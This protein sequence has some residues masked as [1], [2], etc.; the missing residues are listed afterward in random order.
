M[1]KCVKVSLFDLPSL[2]PEFSLNI[3]TW[4]TSVWRWV[5]STCPLYSL[6]SHWTSKLDEQV[7]EDESPQPALFIPWIF[8]EHPNLMNKCVKMSLLNLPSLFPEFSLNIQT[9]WTSVWRWVSST[10]P[11][12]SLNFHWTSKLDEQVCDGESPQPALYLPWILIE[13]PNLMNKCVKVSLLNLPSLFPEFS[14][15]ILTWWTSVWRWVSSTCPLYSLNSH[16]T[17]KLDEQVCE[18]ESPQPALYLPWILIEHPNL[19][20]KCVK[21]SLLNLPSLFPEFSL[22]IRTWWTSV[23]RWVSSTCP[24][25][26]LNSHWTFKLD[27]K[28]VKV[29]L[30]LPSFFPEFSLN[31]QTWWTSV[32]RW[33]SSTCP[34]YSLNSHWIS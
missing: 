27:N 33:V 6:N 11:L 25:Y 5:S 29:S 12:Y 3:R 23:W 9:W 2:V 22:N 15:N 17:S 16:W 30:N 31:I 21:V 7:C 26:S 34:L 13:H 1:N 14:L 32:W 19:M 10:C 20:N 18:G 24:L 28:C 4:W 8:I